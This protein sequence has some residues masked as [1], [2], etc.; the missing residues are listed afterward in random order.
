MSAQYARPLPS[1]RRLL[2]MLGALSAFGPLSFD[3][4]LPGLP[5]LTSDLGAT[6]TGGQLSLSVS[7][8]GLGLGQVVVGPLSDQVGRRWPLIIGVTL[9]TVAAV[10][11]ALTPNLEFLL[12]ARFLGGLGGGAG[13][14]IARSMVRD[15]YSG[16]EAARAFGITAL[17]FG[18][19]PVVAPLLG[20]LLLVVTGWRG[21]FVAIALCGAALLVAAVRLPDT[22]PPEKRKDAKLW[23]L[24]SE[25]PRVLRDR[26]FLAPALVLAIGFQPLSLYLAMSSFA[27]QNG[28]GLSAQQFGYLFAAN[29]V[30]ILLLGRLNLRIVS[31][32]GS[33][34]V[35][36]WTLAMSIV[37]CLAVA[38]A[39]H[40]EGASVWWVIIPLFFAISVAGP[41]LPNATTLALEGQGQ[42][43]G[44]AAACIGLVQSLFG[45]LIPP[46]VSLLGVTPQLMGMSMAIASVLCVVPLLAVP[47]AARL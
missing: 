38:V 9:F 40:V 22:L 47:R 24:F 39:T 17:V 15:L 36:V 4:Y 32:I 25:F 31:I 6:D 35:L 3:M 33:F 28:Y 12:I 42:A 43:I 45:A 34:R 44:A 37:A 14:V 5:Q 10:A 2:I 11:C 7:M 13:A 26:S 19:A 30:G 1:R 20:A 41:L 21:I 16:R 23:S 29:S 27:M 8:I 18:V 46:M